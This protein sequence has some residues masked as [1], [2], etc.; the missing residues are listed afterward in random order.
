MNSN[1]LHCCGLAAAS[2][3]LLFCLSGPLTA[4]NAGL[5]AVSF[6]DLQRQIVPGMDVTAIDS[7]G[8]KTHGEITGITNAGLVIDDH[9]NRITYSAES[10]AEVR[11]RKQDS[12]LN[13][14]LIGAAAGAAPVA[15]M[16]AAFCEEEACNKG[17]IALVTAM[18]AGVGAGIGILID[19]L[20]QKEVVIYR[21]VQMSVTAGKTGRKHSPRLGLSVRW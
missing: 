9:G 21:D 4:E 7:A 10:L 20:F 13:G 11:Q 18:Y 6:A 15:L 12:L 2:C 16:A 8:R 1:N 5:P 17:E 14:A 3:L 19:S